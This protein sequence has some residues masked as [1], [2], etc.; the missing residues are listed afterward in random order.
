[1]V[2][3]SE[4]RGRRAPVQHAVEVRLTRARAVFI[5]LLWGSF[6]RTAA[7]GVALGGRRSVLGEQ[8]CSRCSGRLVREN[9]QRG[10]CHRRGR[11]RSR[12]C[13]PSVRQPSSPCT[14]SRARWCS[15]IP[16]HASTHPQTHDEGCCAQDGPSPTQGHHNRTLYVQCRR[17]VVL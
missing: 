9:A 6:T 13:S 10:F 15:P 3:I 14:A 17:V 11:S 7:S 12:A 16:R 8:T 4:A 2:E 1:M 5:P